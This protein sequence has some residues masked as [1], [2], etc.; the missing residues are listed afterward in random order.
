MVDI[1]EATWP[2]LY[3]SFHPDFIQ[4]MQVPFLLLLFQFIIQAPVDDKQS[5]K[6]T[7]REFFDVILFSLCRL[8]SSCPSIIL[9]IVFLDMNQV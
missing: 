6:K 9:P 1:L 4:K 7:I 2:N 3:S 5:L 8:V